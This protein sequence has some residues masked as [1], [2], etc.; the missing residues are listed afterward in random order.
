M[1]SIKNIMNPNPI[2][3]SP[4]EKVSDVA[5]KMSE[6]GLG[7][8]LVVESDKISGIFSERDLL[9]RVVSKGLNPEATSIQDVATKNPVSVSQDTKIKECVS[10][11]KE[12]NFRH[13][14]VI[15]ANSKPI[16]II[17]TRD[18]LSYIV[19]GLEKFIDQSVYEKEIKEGA[20]PYDHI[21]GGY[22]K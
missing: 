14:P 20:D 12:K 9:N 21:G 4:S 16:G 11:I 8:I 1:S 18:F 15:D 17:S 3:C 19:G 13:L 6:K 22:D 10:I 5:K 2:T 7:A